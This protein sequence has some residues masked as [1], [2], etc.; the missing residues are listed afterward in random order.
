MNKIKINSNFNNDK[1]QTI[2]IKKYRDL[3][4]TFNFSF[5]TK[6]KKYN[7]SKSNGIDKDVRLKILEKVHELSQINLSDVYLESKIHGFEK[8][9]EIPWMKVHSDFLNTGRFHD[10]SNGYWVFRLSKKGRV[11]GKINNNIFYIL[12]IDTKFNLYDH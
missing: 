4:L 11:I 9:A 6:D 3:K 8:L 12:A 10:C 7:L 5:L 1:N 2:K